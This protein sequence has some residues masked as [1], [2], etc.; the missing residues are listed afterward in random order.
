MDN[1][2]NVFHILLTVQ[3]SIIFVNKQLYAQFFLYIYTY[4]LHVSDSHVP[5]IRRII[6]INAVPVIYHSV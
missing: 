6:C 5:I 1:F 4:S 3:L 2:L